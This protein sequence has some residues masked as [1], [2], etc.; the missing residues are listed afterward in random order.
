MKSREH[1]FFVAFLTVIGLLC[2]FIIRSYLVLLAVSGAIS[3]AI[4]PA[5]EWINRR[6]VRGRRWAAALLTIL[7]GVLVIAVP[8]GFLGNR[9]IH[10]AQSFF[11]SLS[12]GTADAAIGRISAS[13]NAILPDGLGL[14]AG[15]G[16]ENLKSFLIAQAPRALS[17]T[18]VTAASAILGIF[19][20]FYFLKD[21]DWWRSKIAKFSPLS[22]DHD[23]AIISKLGRSVSGIL[24]GYFVIAIIQGALLGVGLRIF[25]VPNPVLFGALAAFA[26][27]VPTIGTASVSVPSVIY[28][29]IVGHNGSAIGLLVWAAVLVG[30]ID[31]FLNP[32]IV[33]SQIDLNPVV[34]L[35]A[36]LGGIA[37]FG[38]AGV[39]LGPLS[40]SLFAAMIDIY[41]KDFATQ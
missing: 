29:L 28:L 37:L 7:L 3:V 9:I 21:A 4:Y 26:S 13:L 5:F 10:E 32:V 25:G 11:N 35:F 17:A 1:Y 30:S 39:I 23:N 27:L 19:A 8:L 41:S 12:D 15:I 38:P 20:V 2:L 33:G 36:A 34:I 14:D 24:R 40:A 18:I 22:R 6:I 16:L 31:N